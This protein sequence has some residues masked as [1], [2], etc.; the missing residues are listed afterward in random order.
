MGN[1]I[2]SKTIQVKTNILERYIK[3]FYSLLISTLSEKLSYEP[4][5]AH[6]YPVSVYRECLFSRE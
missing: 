2:R 4:V 6:Y 1:K 5:P 3:V